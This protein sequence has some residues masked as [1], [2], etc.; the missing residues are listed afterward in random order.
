MCK[1]ETALK[2]QIP[3]DAACKT[4]TQVKS[5]ENRLIEKK[6]KYYML[7]AAAEHGQITTYFLGI[8]RRM[9]M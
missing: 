9:N 6:Y 4:T 2:S 8:W 1:S 3:C 5:K 7:P